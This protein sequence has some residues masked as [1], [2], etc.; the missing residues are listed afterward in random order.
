MPCH[1]IDRFAFFPDC[2]AS[3]LACCALNYGYD[4]GT[5]SGVQ[6]MQSFQREFGEY[7]PDTGL[8]ALPGW[9]SSVMTATP[10]IGKAIVGFSSDAARRRTRDADHFV[11]G[12]ICCGWMAERWGRRVAILGLCI[13]SVV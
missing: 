11:Q 6:A 12:C 8:W 2:S 4:V 3:Y 9:L 13:A 10:F 5:F 1:P 7:N